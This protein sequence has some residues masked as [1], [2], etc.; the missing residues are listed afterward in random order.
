M[1]DYYLWILILSLAAFFSMERVYCAINRK[2]DQ[3]TW[4]NVV[5]AVSFSSVLLY[6]SH[7]VV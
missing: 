1:L 2:H 5:I 4:T 7:L 6:L 3:D